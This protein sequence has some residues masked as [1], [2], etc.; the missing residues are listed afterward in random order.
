MTPEYI[1]THDSIYNYLVQYFLF[2]LSDPYFQQYAEQDIE[3]HER[4]TY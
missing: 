2:D 4:M 1:D 3:Q